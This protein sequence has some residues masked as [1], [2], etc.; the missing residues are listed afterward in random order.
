MSGSPSIRSVLIRAPTLVRSIAV[1]ATGNDYA[2][3]TTFGPT[4]QAAALLGAGI[5]NGSEG[6]GAYEQA[7]GTV[8]LTGSY[9]SSGAVDSRN[10]YVYK[11]TA[12]ANPDMTFGA[13]TDGR[14]VIPTTGLADT[15]VAVTLGDGKI[16]AV[17]TIDGK[18]AAM[19]LSSTG[20][21][22][23]SFGTGGIATPV[24][25][26]VESVAYSPA[27]NK[28]V[29][30]SNRFS[31][32]TLVRASADGVADATFGSGGVLEPK[33]PAAFFATDV[34]IQTD[35]KILVT[36]RVTGQPALIVLRFDASGAVDTAFGTAGVAS[37]DLSA[38][39]T[40]ATASKL[41]LSKDGKLWL[42]GIALRP[43]S[44]NPQMFVAKV[45][46]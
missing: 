44:S 39:V 46:L 18:V 9:R 7:N 19:R 12:A 15:R 35:G 23:T 21:Q 37:L 1:A 34:A 27:T 45:D 17:G 2:G 16:I 11:L 41:Q 25:T 4:G 22:D 6:F 20:A 28:V 24:A 13:A 33:T 14:A 3:D 26:L 10:F 36:G 42:G 29:A 43:G 38:Q 40:S 30:L 8:L 5:D 31:K 32:V